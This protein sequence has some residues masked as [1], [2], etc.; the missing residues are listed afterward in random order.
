MSLNEE[1][2]IQLS[3]FEDSL[4]GDV[5]TPNLGALNFEPQALNPRGT[6]P[7]TSKA[8]TVCRCRANSARRRQ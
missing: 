1:R 8:R 4:C 5:T 2:V 7:G 3:F 6:A